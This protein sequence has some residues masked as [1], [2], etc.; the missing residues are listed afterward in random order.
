MS[1]NPIELPEGLV[2]ARTTDVFDNDAVP[3]GLLRAHRVADN[4][5]GRLVVHTGAV[6]F[7]FDDD[8]ARPI[9][10]T[11]GGTVI[12]PPARLHH[13]ELREPSTF[14]VEFWKRPAPEDP[15][16]SSWSGRGAD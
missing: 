2:L 1:V 15:P 9:D 7:V 5:W 16:R 8:A 11:A 12:I 4:V 3:A 6:R 13:L 14:S 10:L